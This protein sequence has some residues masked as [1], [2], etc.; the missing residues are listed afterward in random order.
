[1][2]RLLV[3]AIFARDYP[4]IQGCLLFVAFTY[5]LVNLVVDLCYPD[6]R[7]RGWPPNETLPALNALIGG[8]SS[9]LSLL[10]AAIGASSGRPTIR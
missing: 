6:L 2:G 8:G 1:M 9:A 10:L 5:V 3:D 7:S 4:V